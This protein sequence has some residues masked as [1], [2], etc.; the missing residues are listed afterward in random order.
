MRLRMTD[1]RERML[2]ALTDATGEKTKSKAIDRAVEH[3]CR[4][5]GANA[6]HPTGTYEELMSRAI[7]EGSL[8]PG[9][10]AD[11]LNTDSLPVIHSRDYWIGK[12]Q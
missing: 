5:A 1:Y 10:I 12:E 7:D 6:A 4:C 9:E 8:T 11:I 3:Y 2:D